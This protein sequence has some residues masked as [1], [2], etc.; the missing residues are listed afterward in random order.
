MRISEQVPATGADGATRAEGL[1][2][3]QVGGDWAEQTRQVLTRDL[4]VRAS[5]AR[6]GESQAL[7]FR[8][9]HLNLPL[10]AEAADRL[11][12]SAAQ[13][14]RVEHAALEGLYEAVRVFDP[15]GDVD[16]AT[17]ATPFVEWQ[18]RTHLRTRTLPPS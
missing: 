9:L 18:I 14:T 1:R 3:G 5:L 8:A 12:L 4:L 7:R 17:F 15:L 10:L 13:R 6:R 11:G 16:F 2:I